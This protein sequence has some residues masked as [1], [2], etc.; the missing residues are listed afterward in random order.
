MCIQNKT[1]MKFYQVN[2]H[3]F[4][5]EGQRKI[6]ELRGNKFISLDYLFEVINGQIQHLNNVFVPL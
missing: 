2:S 3:Q 6:F 4:D 5:Y 1:Q